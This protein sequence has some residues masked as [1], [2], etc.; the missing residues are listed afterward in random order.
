MFILGV[1]LD[2]FR[3]QDNATIHLDRSVDL[4]GDVGPALADDDAVELAGLDQPASFMDDHY[5]VVLTA[6]M[7]GGSRID[8][9]VGVHLTADRQVFGH[10][11]VVVDLATLV[12]HGSSVVDDRGELMVQRTLERRAEFVQEPA[13]CSRPNISSCGLRRQTQWPSCG[14]AW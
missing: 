6:D 7:E 11:Q 10:V 1:A 8:S 3:N 9:D 14:S 4:A 12:E 2:P 13:A 5:A